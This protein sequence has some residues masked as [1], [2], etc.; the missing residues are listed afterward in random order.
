MNE[1]ALLDEKMGRNSMDEERI[2]SSLFTSLFMFK[3][4]LLFLKAGV[5]SEGIFN[6]V[7]FKLTFFKHSFVCT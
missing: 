3:C 6:L 2:F 4:L 7:S 5:I 1:L